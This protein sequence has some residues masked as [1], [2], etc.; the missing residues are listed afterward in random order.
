VFVNAARTPRATGQK[1]GISTAKPP[2][3]DANF[4]KK[5]DKVLKKNFTGNEVT[6]AERRT[7]ESSPLLVAKNAAVSLSGLA[8]SCFK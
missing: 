6:A 8:S 5:K 1:T 7:I 3:K 4:A 2:P